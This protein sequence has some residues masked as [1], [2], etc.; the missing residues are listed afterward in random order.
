MRPALFL[1]AL[2]ST[3]ALAQDAANPSFNLVNRGNQVITEVYA[4]PSS[5]DRW[6]GDRLARF[7]LPPGRT[8][9]VRLPANGSCLY[10]IRVVY[11]GR[12]P[13]E[14]RRVDVCRVDSV[15]FPGARSGPGP[16]TR[17]AAT[18]NDPSFRL[19]NRGRQEVNQV[20]ASPTGDDDWGADRLGDDTLGAG[21]TR[22]VRL[23]T[24]QC[25]WDVRVVFADGASLERRKVDL[26]AITDLRVP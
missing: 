22:V 16:A 26:C 2:L 23:P 5:T 8:F 9:P 14:V 19:V 10:D 11:A 18:T 3:P 7:N 24:G 21:S 12:A 17:N 20:Y 6:G 1:L 13:E 15:A 25:T 4:T